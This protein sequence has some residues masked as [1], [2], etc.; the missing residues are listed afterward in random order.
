MKFHEIFHQIL[1]R[2]LKFYEIFFPSKCIKYSP[3]VDEYFMKIHEIF[4]EI[5]MNI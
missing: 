5:F 4:Y 3:T 2:F 1:L